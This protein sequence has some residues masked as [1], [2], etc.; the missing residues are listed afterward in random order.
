MGEIKIKDKEIVVPGEVIASG[1]DYLPASGTVRDADDII[2]TQVGVVNISGRLLRLIPLSGVYLP[3]FG[4]TIIGEIINITL[5]GWIVN[6]GGPYT[7]MITLKEATSDFLDRKADLSQIYDI[8]DMVVA[9]IINVTKQKSVDLTTKGP[10]LRR[11]RG[12]RIIEIASAKVPRV[13]GKQASMI[14]LIKEKTNCKLIV[15][16]NGKVWV[17]SIDPLNE[18]MA[19]KAIKLIERR[20]HQEGLTDEV[21]EFLEKK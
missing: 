9:K 16:Q 2:A 17:Q 3:K 11:L 10:G 6:M 1:M 4:D 15:G 19:I 12:G 5:N 8:G 7:A 13:I 14:S 20:A 21:K 18:L